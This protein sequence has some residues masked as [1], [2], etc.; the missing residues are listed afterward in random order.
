MAGRVQDRDP[1][2]P[3]I[4]PAVYLYNRL[5]AQAEGIGSNAVMVDDQIFTVAQLK[6][7]RD[8]LIKFGDSEFWQWCDGRGNWFGWNVTAAIEIVNDG[9]QADPEHAI[10]L[11]PEI[12]AY[13]RV[14]DPDSEEK[15]RNA[16]ITIPG[17]AVPFYM[18]GK[19]G[20]VFIDGWHRA[21]RAYREGH[22]QYPCHLLTWDEAKECRMS[23]C[24]WEVQDIQHDQD[25]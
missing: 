14:D 23:G 9:R 11:T 10:P 4:A 24:L 20:A 17:I 7:M 16:D 12:I 13:G 19:I 25:K 3:R 1:N 18:D 21:N 2:D 5:I 22:T 6:G 8:D 15:I